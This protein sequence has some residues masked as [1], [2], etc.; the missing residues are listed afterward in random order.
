MRGGL[1][2]GMKNE[3]RNGKQP[4]PPYDVVE[5]F[6]CASNASRGEDVQVQKLRSLSHP[7]QGWQCHL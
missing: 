7:L 2:D 6:F 4:I 5:C 1:P 3:K